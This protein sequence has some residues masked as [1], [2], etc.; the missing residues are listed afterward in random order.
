ML[1]L[2]SLMFDRPGIEYKRYGVI[3]LMLTSFLTL[4]A[5]V[6]NALPSL[7]FLE[8]LGEWQDETGELIDPLLL[9]ENDDLNDV[10]G[11]E[12]ESQ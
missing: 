10:A 2:S 9:G 5:D 4:A 11:S 7:E 3:A 1:S 12:G 8:Y 6:D